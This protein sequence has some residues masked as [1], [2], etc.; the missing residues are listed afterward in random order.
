[1]KNF[2]ISQNY[3]AFY[4]KLEKCNYL[5]EKIIEL[6]DCKKDDRTLDGL[7]NDGIQDGGQWDLFVNI[8]NKYGIVPKSVFQETFQSSNTREID[9][10]LKCNV[11]SL[12]PEIIEN[13]MK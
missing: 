7:L 3:I 11:Y 6:K 8:V 2:E 12:F 13:I 9:G 10:L 4:D 1:M 5:L